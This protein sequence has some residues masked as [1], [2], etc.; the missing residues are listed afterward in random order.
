MKSFNENKKLIESHLDDYSSE[1][2]Y[3]VTYITDKGEEKQLKFSPSKNTNIAGVQKE[4]GKQ[5]KD[6]FKL[7]D[8]K[9]TGNKKTEG[10]NKIKEVKEL[11]DNMDMLDDEELIEKEDLD[12]SKEIKT[13]ATSLSAKDDNNVVIVNKNQYG[14]TTIGLIIDNT[15]NRFQLVTG[16]SLPTGKYRK[17]SK[18]AIRQKAEDLKAQG[19]EEVKGAN[20]LSESK[21]IKT[22]KL[23]DPSEIESTSDIMQGKAL[24]VT[25]KEIISFVED[26]LEAELGKDWK[27]KSLID[28]EDI[29]YDAVYEWGNE[30]DNEDINPQPY[31]TQIRRM[32]GR[33][34]E[35]VTTPK[36]TFEKEEL[37]AMEQEMKDAFNDYWNGKI[38][39]QDLEAVKEK[40]GKYLTNAQITNC[41]IEANQT[42]KKT[43]SKL[44]ETD[45]F[46]NETPDEKAAKEYARERGL[47]S[48]DLS[49]DELSNEGII[50]EYTITY[51]D[52]SMDDEYF[53]NESEARI[54]FDEIQDEGNLDKVGQFFRKEWKWDE[55][56]QEYVEGDVEVYY[57]EGDLIEESNSDEN[58][59][60][61][62]EFA[63]GS[64]PYIKFT[65]TKAE[66]ESEIKKWEKEYTLETIKDL[67][68]RIFVKATSK[69]PDRDLFKVE[70]DVSNDLL[71][72]PHCGSDNI[73]FGNKMFKLDDNFETATTYMQC[74]DCR[75]FTKMTYKLAD[76]T[77]M[78]PM[79]ESKLDEDAN[80]ITTYAEISKA[81]QDAYHSVLP[82]CG[83]SVSKGALGKDTFFIT[84]YLAGNNSEFPNGISQNDLFRIGFYIRPDSRD[85]NLDID[86]KLPETLTMEVTDN[87]ILTKPDNKYMAYGSERVPLRKVSGTPEKLVQTITKYAQKVKDILNKLVAEDRIPNDR[88][89]LVKAKL[90]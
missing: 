77:P 16:Q 48:E 78:K 11:E 70:E 56:S 7:K 49:E 31:Y 17:A 88:I 25:D 5:Y 68:N 29:V 3:S 9:E 82:D 20:S 33:L 67:G 74:N 89:E 43:E 85:A 19:Y 26:S 90:K 13:E 15:N 54:R 72:C 51:N 28:M 36:G 73:T 87:S 55:A 21:E 83:C 62:I 50:I 75:K 18:K 40:L 66:L 58:G 38:S 86:A 47:Y 60:I 35:A 4:L 71:L 79:G 46:G 63:D 59:Y 6:F 14:Y 80:G 34:D 44:E 12:E 23:V 24:T 30:H 81:I 22:E 69:E 10:M 65:D 61:Y 64:N 42:E 57:T 52:M 39:V 45:I 32:I 37:D 8:I 1:K 2:S 41:Q 27:K 84:F 53:G 76:S